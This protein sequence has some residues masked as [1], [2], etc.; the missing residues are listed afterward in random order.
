MRS[1]ASISKNSERLAVDPDKV[2]WLKRLVSQGEGQHLEFKAKTNFPNKI[3]HEFIAFANAYGGTLLVGISDDGKISGV[4][5][6]EED[7]LLIRKALTKYCWPRIKIKSTTIKV[8]EK[9][10]VVVFDVWESRRKPIRFQETRKNIFT[11]IRHKDKTLQATPE[12][13]EILRLRSG[14]KPTWFTYEEMENKLLKVLSIKGVATI[15]ELH[16]ITGINRKSL[17]AKL[18]SLAG[19]NGI[20]WEPGDGFDTYHSLHK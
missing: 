6:P 3:I 4:K 20:G 14:N 12:A 8:S 19:S 17:S 2:R 10:W 11:Y 13:I 15:D 5:Y 18:I 1:L 16:Q 9:K 7:E